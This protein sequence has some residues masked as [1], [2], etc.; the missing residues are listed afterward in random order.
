MTKYQ[1]DHDLTT[2]QVTDEFLLAGASARGGW[3]HE[4][5]RLL[6][7]PWPAQ[8]GWKRSLL[9]TTVDAANARRFLEIR[10]AQQAPV[11]VGKIEPVARRE[12]GTWWLYVL[13]LEND[14]YYVGMTRDVK[15]RFKQHCSGLGT[16]AQW[17]A[18]HRPL[19]ILRSIDTGLPSDSLTA[20]V[21]DALTVQ[22][23]EQFG[24]ERVRGGKYCML[25]Q[26]EVDATLIQQ[27]QWEIVERAA[28]GRRSYELQG[29]WDTALD[30]VLTVA[31]Q[32]YQSPSTDSRERLFAAMYGLTRYRFW[33]AD[34]D[35][36]LDAA[37][38]DE[39]GILPV[40]LSFRDNRPVASNCQ[41][42]FCV[43]GAAMSRT[44]RHGPPLH[45]LFMFGWTA[46]VPSCT[47][48]QELKAAQWQRAL[49]KDRDRRYDEFTSILL[50]K[51]RY[52]LRG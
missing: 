26:A 45:H 28:L 50:P 14:N 7:I 9:G 23:M 32:H 21:E 2:I 3:T 47:S 46:F 5:L 31:L 37:Y 27:G 33:H 15:L 29:H 22:M 4:Q 38:W 18:L 24:R 52:L 42:A 41:D 39:K 49:P 19:R 25:D 48:V 16:G 10:A 35:E 44:R 40:L 34:F 12:T 17:T 11:D 20:R 6:G 43:L 36:A 1:I 30:N 8:K 51:M 13:A